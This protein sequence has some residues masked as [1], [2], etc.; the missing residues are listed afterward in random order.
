LRTFTD[1][2]EPVK[3]YNREELAVVEATSLSPLNRVIDAA[4]PESATARQFAD[5][6]DAIVA[7]KANAQSK[8]EARALL[9]LWRDNQANLQPLEAQ[10][11]LL[12]EIVP[13]SQ[14]L[15]AVSTT[16]LQAL[17]YIDRGER[18]SEAWAGQQFALLEQAQ[19]PKAQLLLVVVPSVQK[20]VEASS[21]Q[22]APPQK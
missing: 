17:D 1:V 21:G 16:G 7:G 6:V 22:K 11:F 18:A 9:T 15:S 13:L 5:L 2:V 8:Q 12:K 19:K 3:D 14:D 10:S 20:L 4:R